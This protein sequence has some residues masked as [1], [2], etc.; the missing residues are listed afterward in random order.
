MR[1]VRFTMMSAMTL[2][3]AAA[4]ARPATQSAPVA[5][6]AFITGNELHAATS[7]N[8]Y[9][10]ISQL[11]PMFFSSRG[12]TSILN[13]P[14]DAFL[15]IIDGMPHGD[16]DELRN[17]DARLVRSVRRLSV[18]EVFQMTGHPTSAGGVEVVFGP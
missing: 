18:A 1:A 16:I 15:V 11:R 8:L 7:T 10:A 6:L 2:T 13:E 12:R 3:F 4:C 14:R 9:D 5:R 17:I